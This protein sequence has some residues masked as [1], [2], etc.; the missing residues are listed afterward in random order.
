MLDL[1]GDMK[2]RLKELLD[3]Q[4][5]NLLTKIEE[6]MPSLQSDEDT[7]RKKLKQVGGARH[8]ETP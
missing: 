7:S 4:I 8:G 5:A 1:D 6:E 3:S 2:V